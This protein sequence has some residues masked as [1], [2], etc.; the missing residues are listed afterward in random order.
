MAV[1]RCIFKVTE[2]KDRQGSDF[3]ANCSSISFNTKSRI[4]LVSNDSCDTFITCFKNIYDI[5]N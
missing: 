5:F 2:C 1:D 3:E 4:L